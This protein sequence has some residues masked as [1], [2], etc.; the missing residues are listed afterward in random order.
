MIKMS[1]KPGNG[2]LEGLAGAQAV[3]WMQSLSQATVVM[4]PTGLS[5]N[6]N[7]Q[8]ASSLPGASAGPREPGPVGPRRPAHRLLL[9][10]CPPRAWAQQH[11]HSGLTAVWAAM[12]TCL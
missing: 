3:C 5:A 10:F 12:L 1:G 2:Y 9:P 4:C 6:P 7:G 11:P 8:G